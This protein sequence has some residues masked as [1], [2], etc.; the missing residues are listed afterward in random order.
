MNDP[1]LTDPLPHIETAEY[2]ARREAVLVALE[3]AAAVVLAGAPGPAWPGQGRW[4]TDRSF[5]YLT[6]LDHEEGAAILFDPAAEDPERRITLFLRPRDPER[7]RWEGARDPLGAALREK[8]GFASIA[9]T[10]SLAARLTDA[11]RRTKRLAC[12]HPFASYESDVS[13]DLGLFRK[14]CDRVP[15]VVIL[16]RTQ[17]VPA[18]RAVKS[19]AELGLIRRAAKASAAGFEAALGFIRPGVREAEIAETITRAVQEW[20]AEPAFLPIVGSGPNGTVL[21]YVD[22]DALVREGDLVVI[23]YGAAYEGYSSD[24]T[25]TFPADG[26]FT[27]EQRQVYEVVLEANLAAIAAACPGVLMSEVHHTARRVIAEAGL[28]D[29]FIHETGHHLGAEVHDVAPDGPLACGM[30][31]T[32]EPGVYIPERS[33][34]VR[35]EDDILVTETGAVVLTADIPKTVAAIEAAMARR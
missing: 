12:L 14:V 17:I 33:L 27:R 13:P 20:G 1:L 8:T 3:G 10:T 26:V 34:G 29:F 30:V 7:E 22:N 5:W 28:E 25:R 35:I 19:P 11:A 18:M 16:D 23:D 15:G 21:H 2:A 4:K 9:R 6:G 31:I 32:I 24:V